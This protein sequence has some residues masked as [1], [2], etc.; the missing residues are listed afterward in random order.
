MKQ[1]SFTVNELASRLGGSVRGDGNVQVDGVNSLDQATP[2]Q[3][4]FISDAKFAKQWALSKAASAVIDEKLATLNGKGD[5]HRPLII[6]PNA[7]V[8]MIGLLELFVLPEPVPDLG[9][10]PTAFVDSSAKLGKH[11]RIGPHV[12][13]DGG[14]S[15]GDGVVLHAGVRI[16]RDV[17]VGA[18]TVIHA[19]T[20]IR[21]RCRIGRGVIL[22]QNVSIGADGFGYRPAPDGSGLLKVPHLGDVVLH[23]Q[24]EIGAN[25]CVDR[26]K[27]GSTVIGAGTKIDNLVQ[28]AHNCRIGRGCV[29]AGCTGLSGSVSIG[30]GVQIGGGVGISDQLSIGS[31]AKVGGM[32][33]VTRDIPA[34][35]TWVGH[36]A[37]E[38][39]AALRQ[40]ASI[41]KLPE[42]VRRLSKG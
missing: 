9:V 36:P 1:V 40:W 30:D 32:A 4:T 35:A 14:A 2:T 10:H 15:I 26:G 16:Y 13:I 18:G 25:S 8:A 38:S 42:L 22:H 12:S 3:I 17:E 21:H 24:V 28:I 37:D 23:D 29:I 33:F 5:P 20:V 39:T 19:N 7:E 11:V 34:G 6:V 41:R 27:F 31:G